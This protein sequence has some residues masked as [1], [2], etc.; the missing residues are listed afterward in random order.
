MAET[1]TFLPR[2]EVLSLEELE[3][4]ARVFVDLGVRKI[5]VT[6]GEPLV[7][8]GVD[9]FLA[10]LGKVPEL[11]EL[12][13]TTNGSQLASRAVTL[14]ESGLSSVNISLDTLDPAGFTELTRT[15]KL[16]QV[17]AGIDAAV[18]AGIPR[19]RLNAVILS[20]QNEDQVIPLTEFAIERGID[21]AFIEE[22]PL[23]QVTQGGKPLALFDSDSVLD[24]LRD[25]WQ[26]NATTAG[27]QSGPARYFAIEGSDSRIGV[28]SPHSNNFC[29][30]CNRLRVTA[31]GRL[32]LCLG[33]E[34]SISL[35]DLMRQGYTDSELKS[36][37][38]SALA[39]KPERHHFD[40]PDEPQ[41][42]RFMNASGG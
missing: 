4:V 14:R 28:I 41:I 21:I 17:I 16:S 33:N 12:A 37:I 3:R 6:G 32:L 9:E 18:A 11:R 22:M 29:G 34:H 8:R 23:G 31:E 13:M 40:A 7:R 38:A 35:R 25:Q 20:G 30:A 42:I 5:R 26:L 1:M 19:I 36:A 15:G 39:A 24:L 27:P 10:N 2:R